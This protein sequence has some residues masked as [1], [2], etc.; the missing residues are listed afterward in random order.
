MPSRKQ[1]RRD[2]KLRRH[3]Y[4]EVYLDADG[5]ELPAEEVERERPVRATRAA[6]SGKASRNGAVPRDARGRAIR[7]VPPPTWRRAFRR[8]AIF[9]PILVF[10]LIVTSKSGN[11]TSQ[12]AVGVVY[13][14]LL[15]PFMY[16][17]DR[18][19]YRLYLR[20]VGEAQAQPQPRRRREP[21]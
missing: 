19:T 8:W 21:K 10:V 16:L 3:E 9:G 12:V 1:R 2:A 4:E 7:E 18:L 5:N 6:A 20:R 13:A 11:R 17:L 14:I 15:L